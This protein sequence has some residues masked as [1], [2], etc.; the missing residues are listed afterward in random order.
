MPPLRSYPWWLPLIAVLATRPA[1]ADD[2]IKAHGQYSQSYLSDWST[3]PTGKLL[4][5]MDLGQVSFDVVHGEAVRK[6]FDHQASV[7]IRDLAYRVSWQ[8]D[9]QKYANALFHIREAENVVIENLAI[10]QDDA[11]YRSSSALL[12]EDSGNV[13]IRNVYVAGS[14]QSFHIRVEGCENV[15]IERIEIAGLDYG[16]LGVRTGG[17]IRVDNGKHG[18]PNTPHPRPLKWLVIQHVYG[19]DYLD[20]PSDAGFN[21]DGILAQSVADGLL[22]NSYFE[23]WRKGNSAIDVSHRLT[24]PDY[25]N[26][27]FR[28]ERNI[29]R[30]SYTVKVPD[31]STPSN[32]IVFANNVYVNTFLVSYNTGYDVHRLH[33][34]S[35]I[36]P[37]VIP[38]YKLWS[39][40]GDTVHHFRNGLVVV[41]EVTLSTVYFNSST[42]PD[43]PSL[44]DPDYMVYVTRTP[45][46]WFRD[47]FADFDSWQAAGFDK[48]S[49]VAPPVECFT[50]PDHDDFSLLPGCPAV[51]RASSEY[52][53]PADP[54]MRVDR[55]FRGV[56]R[57]A[58]PSCGAFE[59]PPTP[60]PDDGGGDAGAGGGAGD[61]G[62]DDGSAGVADADSG[63]VVEA[64][65][66]GSGTGEPDASSADSAAG[67]GITG[68]SQPPPSSDGGCGCRTGPSPLDGPLPISVFLGA[69]LLLLRPKR[70]AG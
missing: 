23:N 54:A 17:G 25:Q 48:H 55:D 62:A 56:P 45:K 36:H 50:D 33:E 53:T 26:H 47:Y 49:L 21:H 14:T 9:Y 68:S 13:V 32:T 64:G 38:F 35:V 1:A 27:V 29:V 37:D 31:I 22:F 52:L 65:T 16:P 10:I 20:V 4:G 57:G 66:G 5:R 24:S 70:D 69:A 58:N 30:D 8:N 46:S 63:V 42:N 7:E 51:G 67:F 61:A 60:S 15:L 34:T 59:V 18:P 6:T 28:V 44:L 11:D 39:T 3:L 43:P 12:I 2:I 40:T 19:H 41:P